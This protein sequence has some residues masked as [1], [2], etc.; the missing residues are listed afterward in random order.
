MKLEKIEMVYKEIISLNKQIDSIV[1]DIESLRLKIKEIVVNE[2]FDLDSRWNIF[3]QFA[4]QCNRA[5]CYSVYTFKNKHFQNHLDS[6]EFNR[7]EEVD[8]DWE[9]DNYF[10]FYYDN[11]ELSLEE[12]E[13]NIA[14]V[15][16]ECLINFIY[17]YSNS[18]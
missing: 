6:R 13:A 9:L 4:T 12:L 1:R 11:E 3:C 7:N 2:E 5:K 18:W 14:Q 10:E 8:I 15:K 16:E 17:S